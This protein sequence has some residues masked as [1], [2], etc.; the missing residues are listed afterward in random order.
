MDL[1]DELENFIRKQRARVA[2]DKAS[3]EEDPPYMEMKVKP[4]RSHG[5]TVKNIPPNFTAKGKEESNCMGLPLGIEYER[6][7]QRLQRELH[8]DY[9]RYVAQIQYFNPSMLDAEFFMGGSQRT[10][11]TDEAL[12]KKKEH[13]RKD[14]EAQIVEKQRN[15]K[16]EKDLELKVAAMGINDSEKQPDHIRHFRLSRRGGPPVLEPLKTGESGSS[17]LQNNERP[18]IRERSSNETSTVDSQ[19]RVFTSERS[20]STREKILSY[21]DALKKQIQEQ[22]ELRHLER[23]EEERCEAQ[24]EADRKN[25]QPWGR[26]GGGAPLR[27]YAGNL[28]TDLKQMH[29]LN[30]AAY[31]N[32]EQWHKRFTTAAMAH[33]A[34]RLDP[35]ERISG[36]THVQTPQFARGKV[37]AS[38]STEQQ[39]QKQMKYKADLNQQIEENMR[40]KAEEREQI[41]LEEERLDKEVAE[42]NARMERKYKEEEER[43]KQKQ[44]VVR[45]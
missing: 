6:K 37:F 27:D 18:R 4:F 36:F 19:A 2:A 15:K 38:Q 35:H 43:N 9:R 16:R 11:D 14:L 13:Y 10:A 30:E 34:Q 26:G 42:Y 41:R 21:G 5:S 24:L 33:Q 20:G 23:E 22:Q 40:K 31:S 28:I 17:S 7:K 3:L 45:S 39:L 32:P 44:M 25:H 29:K 1:D 8:M 12:Q